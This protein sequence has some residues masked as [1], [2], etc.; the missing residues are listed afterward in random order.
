MLVVAIFPALV[1][2]TNKKTS[3]TYLA[4]VRYARHWVK[5]IANTVEFVG[6]LTEAHKSALFITLM[7]TAF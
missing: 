2:F 1:R 5:H 4:I 7:S 3:A 6:V